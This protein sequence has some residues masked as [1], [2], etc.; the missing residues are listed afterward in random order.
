MNIND[1]INCKGDKRFTI[2]DSIGG[3][4]QGD[5]WLVE[6]GAGQ[7]YAFKII[8]ETD[9]AKK[10]RKIE[11]IRALKDREKLLRPSLNGKKFSIAFPVCLYEQNGDF[12][13]I[14][15]LCS[16]KSINKMMLDKKFDNMILKKRLAIVRQIAESA[17]WLAQN[18]LCYQ[19]FSHKN[20]MYDGAENVNSTGLE[21]NGTV[22]LI[23]CDNIAP[24][25]A[26]KSGE[27]K[28]TAG[29][30]FYVAPEVAFKICP[31]SI[32]SDKYALAVL[33]FKI[34]TGSTDSPYHG[35]ELYGKFRPRPA[36]MIEAAQECQIDPYIDKKWL[37]F[38][39]DDK[40]T[41]NSINPQQ[42]KK[43]EFQDRQNMILKNWEK[44]PDSMK[45]MFRKAFY[46]PLDEKARRNRP[47]AGQWK[48]CAK[49]EEAELSKT[50][51]EPAKKS[52]PTKPAETRVNHN[53][54]KIVFLP[55]KFSIELK[56]PLTL[57]EKISNGAIARKMGIIEKKGND[58]VFSSESYMAIGYCYKGEEERTLNYGQTLVLKNDTELF[59]FV[60]SKE[61]AKISLNN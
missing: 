33:L 40:D 6:D 7:K 60:R 31:P 48:E 58:Y 34:M 20:F 44:V 1:I 27:A 50:S 9:E 11:N 12:G 28:Y 26:A 38:V 36:D 42:F 49:N 16:G 35:K 5:V 41:V 32:E 61:R 54:P 25:S 55:N 4:G 37:T 43:P 13:Y 19:D 8:K 14:M 21:D 29:T 53:I 46:K 57:D 22:S 56:C 59:F 17:E 18:G 10:K 51:S 3:G 47:T 23:D 15:N 30:G 24:N 45:D 2:I 39:F 52:V